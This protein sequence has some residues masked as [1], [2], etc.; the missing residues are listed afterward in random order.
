MDPSQV[1]KEV[2]C[3]RLTY[4]LQLATNAIALSLSST[5]QYAVPYV[6]KPAPYLM[7][8][9]QVAKEVL[10]KRLTYWLQPTINANAFSPPRPKTPSWRRV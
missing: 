3:K 4:W 9:S 1:A 10:C 8:P 5:P 7:D 2:L 6:I